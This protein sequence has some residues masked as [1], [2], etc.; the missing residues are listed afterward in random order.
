MSRFFARRTVP[1]SGCELAQQQ[2]QQRRLARA[3]RPDEARAGRRASRAATGR[4]R[5]A[6]SPSGVWNIFVRPFASIT[7][8]PDCAP[9][10]MARFAVLL[11]WFSAMRRS[12][13]SAR[14]SC[15]LRTRP[16]LRLRRAVTPR[17]IQRSSA[18][19]CDVELV[20]R[21]L[22]V[23]LDR[24]GPLL[25]GGIALVQ[26][27][28]SPWR[29]HAT[30]V[31]TFSRKRRSWLT[32]SAAPRNDLQLFFQQFDRRHVEVVGRLV[33]Q[34]DVRI[35]REGVGEG[36]AP[37]LS[38]RR[39]LQVEIERHAPRTQLGSRRDRACPDPAPRTRNPARS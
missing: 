23:R 18:F 33:Q 25:E 21:L 37:R 5:S 4:S 30:D 11:A 17:A 34:Q 22:L 16:M 32:I 6:A 10:S 36:D 15:S 12:F 8:R 7:R 3:V 2:L 35:M 13:F 28:T 26:L 20:E 31:E 1:L 29:S 24:L 19:S 27:R 9:A 39:L 38:A 14:I